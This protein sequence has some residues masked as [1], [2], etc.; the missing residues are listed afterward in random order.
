MLETEREQMDEMGY[1]EAYRL[2]GEVLELYREGRFTSIRVLYASYLNSISHEVKAAPV[3]PLEA[4]GQAGD[5]DLTLMEY[6]PAGREL[7]DSLA[8]STWLCTC[9]VQSRRRP[10]VSIRRAGLR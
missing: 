1:E 2:S 6:E 4:G 3:I 10:C 8:Q 7:F 9:T 5:C